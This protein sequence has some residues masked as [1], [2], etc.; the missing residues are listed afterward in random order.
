MTSSPAEISKFCPDIAVLAGVAT[1]RLDA[2]G[3]LPESLDGVLIE[4]PLASSYS[5]GVELASEL[6][7]RSTFVQ[8]GYNLRFSPSLRELKRRVDQEDLGEVLAVH[9]ETGQYLPEWRPERDYRFTASAQKSLGGGAL[10]ELSHEIDYL[11]WIFGDVIWVSAWMGRTSALDIDVEDTAHIL[12]SCSSQRQSA[13]IVTRVSLDLVR[14]DSKRCVTVVCAAGSLR[15]DGIARTVEEYRTSSGSWREVF[16]EQPGGSSTYERQWDGFFSSLNTGGH[17]E[18]STDDGLAV[19]KVVDAARES[20][21]SSG[22]RVSLANYG[23]L[24]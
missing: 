4:K 23:R 11:R 8:V 2:L 24:S 21:A 17:P 20:N 6:I 16:A 13:E 9:V 19:L 14:R 5:D 15:W 10:L 7:R 22:R 18:V 1:D 12:M 3:W